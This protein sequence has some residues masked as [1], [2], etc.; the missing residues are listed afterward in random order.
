MLW[1]GSLYRL[2]YSI[3]CKFLKTTFGETETLKGCLVLLYGWEP[4]DD[5]N[6][7]Y[8]VLYS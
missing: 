4:W 5:E 8:F 1:L 3:G 6:Y 7:L 2:D